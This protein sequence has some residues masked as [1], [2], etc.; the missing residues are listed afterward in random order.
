MSYG[1]PYSLTNF[2]N[3]NVDLSYGKNISTHRISIE[4]SCSAH[5]KTPV[6][7]PEKGDQN[8]PILSAVIQLCIRL[9][10]IAL[11][12]FFFTGYLT[13]LYHF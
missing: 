9:N 6:E 13:P 11:I 10:E 5:C 3:V 8:K 12:L 4:T 2:I 7:I 1:R